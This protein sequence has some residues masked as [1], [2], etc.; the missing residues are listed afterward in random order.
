[1]THLTKL[2]YFGSLVGSAG[3]ALSWTIVAIAIV[4]AIMGTSAS[5][6][7]LER[8]SDAQFRK[9]TK[10]IVMGIGSVYIA[11]GVVAYMRG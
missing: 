10:L 7:V 4:A 2:I 6:A 11:Q 5:R 3:N 8:M 1:V 9:W